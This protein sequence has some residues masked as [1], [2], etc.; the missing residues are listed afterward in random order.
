MRYLDGRELAGYIKQRQA[1]EVRRLKHAGFAPVLAI[2]CDNPQPTNQ[3]YMSL[4]KKYG[5]EIGVKVI[6]FNVEPSELANTIRSVNKDETINGLIV[7][8]PMTTGVDTDALLD[9][10]NPDKDVDGLGEKAKF[11]PA[12]P[13]AILWLLAGYGIELADKKIAIV[14]Q[15]RLVGKPLAAMLRNSGIEP[16]TFD[17]GSKNL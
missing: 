2:I 16:A 10:I 3:L 13:L 5:A 6:D 15:G 8:L 1:K 14:G 9:A 11:D 4:K 7:Q 17:V 12:T